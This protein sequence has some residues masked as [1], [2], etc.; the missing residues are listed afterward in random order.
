MPT[1]TSKGFRYRTF[2]GGGSR[3]GPGKVHL[4]FWSK[5][6]QQWVLCCRQTDVGPFS[7]IHGWPT[8]ELIPTT[9]IKCRHCDARLGSNPPPPNPPTK[10]TAMPGFYD[11]PDIKKA[12]EGGEY[13]KFVEVGDTISG[14][15]NK[16][17]KRDF[18]GRTA[19]EVEMDGERKVTFGQVLMLR[20]LYVLQ[21]EVGDTLTVTLAEV[22]KRGA[23]TLKMFR[24]EI[25]RVNGDVET[26]DQTS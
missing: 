16:L 9:C 10:E 21:P 23:K 18:D 1:F 8:D 22:Q 7:G 24:G 19:I 11:D 13:A 6:H 25:T 26:F 20:D 17:T 3:W 15:I 5:E 12:A 2:E 4:Q 14:T